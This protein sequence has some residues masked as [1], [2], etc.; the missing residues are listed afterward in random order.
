MPDIFNA[1]SREGKRVRLTAT[2]WRK[3]D[4]SHPELASDENHLDDIRTTVEDPDY[5]IEGWAGELLALRRCETAPG[6]PKQ[7]C[8]VY[9]EMD[10]DGFIITA[11]FLSR[12]ERLLRR[13][14]R[15]SRS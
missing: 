2:V 10:D 7:L 6:G 12:Y 5:V 9:R 8:V 14:V 15:W 13:T 11:F 3:I 4:R 1:V